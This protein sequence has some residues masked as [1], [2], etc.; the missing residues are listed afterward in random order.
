MVVV[1]IVSIVAGLAIPKYN[2][3]VQRTRL[4][5][6]RKTLIYLKQAIK[7]QRNEVD[8][9]FK[10]VDENGEEIPIKHIIG[11]NEINKQ[12]LFIKLSDDSLFE[13]FISNTSHAGIDANADNLRI[14]ARHPHGV[15]S[16]HKDSLTLITNEEDEK[17]KAKFRGTTIY[18]PF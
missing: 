2:N 8:G 16:S 4:T 3:L 17:F 10:F 15:S 9:S 7:F 13:Y 14:G 12:D 1:S 6:A 18:K 11:N 5:E